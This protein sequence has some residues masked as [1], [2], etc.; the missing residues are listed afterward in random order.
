MRIITLSFLSMKL[1]QISLLHCIQNGEKQDT[2]KGEIS[3]GFK[4]KG[5]EKNH[6]KIRGIPPDYVMSR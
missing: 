5:E 3:Q 6:F 1:L 2:R 4:S